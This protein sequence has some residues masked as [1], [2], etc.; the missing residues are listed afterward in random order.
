M[1]S[2]E[3]KMP[4]SKLAVLLR[5]LR[6]SLIAYLPQYRGYTPFSERIEVDSPPPAGLEFHQVTYDNV[7]RI[8]EWKGALYV[9]RFRA[10]LNRG[11][12]GLYGIMDGKVVSHAWVVVKLDA[13]SPAC[14]HDLLEAGEVMGGRAETRPE[15]RRRGIASHT[16]AHL[17]ELLRQRYGDRL[18]R[19]WGSGLVTNEPMQELVLRQDIIRCQELHTVVILR[20]LYLYRV[21][22]LL[23]NTSQRI[24]RGRLIVRIRVPDF[25]FSPP[26][27]WL[28]LGPQPVASLTANEAGTSKP[29]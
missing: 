22:D 17:H 6:K 20:Y 10:L 4:D 3:T 7:D 16:R 15:Y 8:R 24:G 23:P 1:E 5:L 12:L 18:K 2:E 14:S 21:W 9:Q 13:Q 25:L 11:Y 29:V 19:M 27:K 28:G 26:F